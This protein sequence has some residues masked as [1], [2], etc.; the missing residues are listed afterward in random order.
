MGW[1]VLGLFFYFSLKP[2]AC[3]RIPGCLW[4]NDAHWASPEQ[5]QLARQRTCVLFIYSDTI[6]GSFS[7][8]HNIPEAKCVCNPFWI[9]RSMWHGM[10]KETNMF[11]IDGLP[12]SVCIQLNY[13]NFKYDFV[14]Y[15]QQQSKK[16]ELGIPKR[17][18]GARTHV[19][20][21][22]SGKIPV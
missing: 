22:C 13:F 16:W 19:N 17:W 14:D 18:P 21:S 5:S 7:I 3:L 1:N 10:S 6:N 4:D 8:H 2:R 15:R 9:N 11:K 12:P 20:C